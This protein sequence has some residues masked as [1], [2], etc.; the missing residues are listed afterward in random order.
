[1][2]LARCSCLDTTGKIEVDEWSWLSTVL[3]AADCNPMPTG[4]KNADLDPFCGSDHTIF[5]CIPATQDNS[6]ARFPA[7]V[8]IC[9]H[10]CVW[11]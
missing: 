9:V 5:F 6:A 10:A 4:K 11:V 8:C 2:Q 7:Y 1:M 3:D